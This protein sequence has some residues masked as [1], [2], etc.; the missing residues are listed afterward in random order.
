LEI[1]VNRK[2]ETSQ[3][4]TSADNIKKAMYRWASWGTTKLVRSALLLV[5]A[6]FVI[7]ATLR[8]APG[9][10]V[11]LILGLGNTAEDKLA[12]RQEFGLDLN[13]ISGYLRWAARA[14]TGDLG[15]SIKVEVGADVLEIAAPAFLITMVIA[16]TSLVSLIL[17]SYLLAA[18]LG[19]P[20]TRDTLLL[21]PFKLLN[22]APSF[23]IAVCVIK[24]VNEFVMWSYG[25]DFI[26]PS[27][28]PLPQ[29][30]KLSDSLVPFLFAVFAISLGDGLFTDLF[31]S[32][33]S[34]LLIV[35]RSL[36]I[37]AVRAKGGNPTPHLIKNLIVPTL[38]V[39]TARLPLVLSAVVIVEYIF[40]LD[41]SGYLL[42][43]AAKNR[44]V[45]VVVG[46]SLFFIFS[47]I[48]MNLILDI[49]KAIVDP[50]EVARGE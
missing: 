3:S 20:R 22:A 12:L 28:Y 45:P 18:L 5:G 41:G 19:P 8:L 47:V 39:F 34:E 29:Y 7:Y 6:S 43:Q 49:V 36:F 14:I 4:N 35:Q 37:N 9:D 42:L 13:F 25:A 40:T 1:E 46:V 31:N 50:R 48:A 27:W 33:R 11:D 32:L 21:G 16:S 15:Q 30:M 17:I 38:S 26:H 23:V 10:V 2:I 24:L 44:D